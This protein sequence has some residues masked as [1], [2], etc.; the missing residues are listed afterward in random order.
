M[1]SSSA[2][3][4]VS[5]LKE[6]DRA[7]RQLGSE[8]EDELKETDRTVAGAVADH[9]RGIAHSIGGVAAKTAPS[10][11][12]SADGLGFGG[13]GYPFAG[14]AE[15][16]AVRYKQFKPW[17]GSGSAAGYFVYEAIRDD[18]EQIEDTYLEGLDNVTQRSGLR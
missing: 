15:F 10:I 12:A 14:G 4:R 18:S 13:G 8:L 1:S 9:A 6:L 2:G 17:R 11:S 3:V 7:L 5:G 16:G